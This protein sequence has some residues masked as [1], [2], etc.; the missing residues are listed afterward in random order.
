MVTSSFRRRGF[1]AAVIVVLLAAAFA[2]LALPSTLGARGSVAAPLAILII[3]VATVLPNV[4]D[5]WTR[6]EKASHG[7][8]VTFRRR[9]VAARARRV[10]AIVLGVCGA[11]ATALV[12]PVAAGESWSVNVLIGGA[13]AALVGYAIGDHILPSLLRLRKSGGE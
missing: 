11:V 7:V 10:L 12:R 1:V 9:Q 5:R 4:T 2:L 6:E 13:V 3:W 8:A